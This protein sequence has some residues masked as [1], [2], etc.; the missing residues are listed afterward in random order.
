M[1]VSFRMCL[2]NIISLLVCN[3]INRV[4][5]R[6]SLLTASRI[7]LLISSAAWL[8]LFVCYFDIRKSSVYG[9]YNIL[10]KL[11]KADLRISP[12]W[13]RY[14]NHWISYVDNAEFAPG[15]LNELC[16][17]DGGGEKRIFFIETSGER[18]LRPRY[19]LL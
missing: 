1:K 2:S 4:R 16:H 19:S 12:N 18:C 6:K 3:S 11:Y 10:I 14:R 8:I 15:K 13:L 5:Q 7:A 9:K 17:S